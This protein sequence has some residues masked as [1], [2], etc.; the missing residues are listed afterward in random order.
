[1]SKEQFPPPSNFVCLSD[2]DHDLPTLTP[3]A[4]ISREPT[5]DD[6]TAKKA[7]ISTEP[8]E[9]VSVLDQEASRCATDIETAVEEAIGSMQ[10]QFSKPIAMTS[11]ISGSDSW[12]RTPKPFPIPKSAANSKIVAHSF[13]RSAKNGEGSTMKPE[14][15]AAQKLV[16]R[17]DTGESTV[18]LGTVAVSRSGVGEHPEPVSRYIKLDKLHSP[19]MNLKQLKQTE[20]AEL[21][22]VEQMATNVEVA[23]VKPETKVAPK[24]I[25]RTNTG[26]S[27][28]KLGTV[29]V[30][31]S[32]TDDHAEIVSRYVKLDE[33]PS[34]KVTLTKLTQTEIAE[35]ELALQLDTNIEDEGWKDDWNGN[36]MLI[37]KD[38]SNPVSKRRKPGKSEWTQPLWEWAKI[39]GSNMR[40]ARNLLAFVYHTK[41]TPPT[42]K[43]I[44]AH[45]S[46]QTEEDPYFDIFEHVKR[47]TYDPSVLREDGWTTAKS[48]HPEGASGGSFH[49]GKLV[50]WQGY[51][52]VVIAYVHD[53]EFGDLWK[54]MWFEGFETFDLEA[55]ELT[56]ATKKW[57]RR[58]KVK[59]ENVN[60]RS[61]AIVSTPSSR[62]AAASS[63]SV[64]GIE[65]G[66]VLATTYNP[67]ARQGVFWPARI[68]HLSELDTTK[69]Q[70]KRNASK[71]K[72]CVVF[73]CPYWNSNVSRGKSSGPGTFADSPLFEMEAIEVS[74][75]AIQKYTYDG[76]N[77]L[78][79]RQ[80]R[81]AFRFTGLPN[82][83]FS[84][85]L[86]SHR[87]ALALKTYAQSEL[88]VVRSHQASAALFDTHI[89]AVHTAQFPPALLHL[90]FNYLL[91]KL[92]VP[93]EE[94]SASQEVEDKIEPVLKLTE[95]LNAMA[96]PRCWGQEDDTVTP[97]NG[98]ISKVLKLALTKSPTPR[99]LA[100]TVNADN[101]NK[102]TKESP[103]EIE[104]VA[105]HFLFEELTN[106]STTECSSASLLDD[107]SRILSRIGRVLPGF[108]IMATNEKAAMLSTLL[109]DC[110]R[111]KV[112]FFNPKSCFQ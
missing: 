80:L 30:S 71:G 9:R 66:V 44:F 40:L 92:P 76:E 63:F 62:F 74:E 53:D 45:V 89:L 84:R 78:N 85:F 49:I 4:F 98:H 79:I 18:K 102:G 13:E 26:E 22:L 27:T 97:K 34:P 67:Q 1:M 77:G 64:D 2:S 43:R 42:A 104:T 88:K 21:E 19:K 5:D 111:L 16:P 32:G 7:R 36:L 68:M 56:A 8:Q 81:G 55:E 35:L 90:P 41:G 28:I 57:E 106:L 33:L 93:D 48:T 15:T 23:K 69:S 58:N 25:P 95:I 107:L 65:H 47:V 59:A 14:T 37:T 99:A 17:T 75:Q 109:H 83:L 100:M 24:P 110:L 112:S 103:L 3:P 82:H 20:I 91:S 86:N 70:N 60:A 6:R 39:G 38:I 12:W 29:A 105:S 46:K 108:Q 10:M 50:Y 11:S 73:L 87:L 72:I 96:P 52:A 94:K 101:Q 31:I 54:A 51:D 61:T